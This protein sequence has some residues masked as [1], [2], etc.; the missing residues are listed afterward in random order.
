ML[1]FFFGN[2]TK[3][4]RSEIDANSPTASLSGGSTCDK[5]GHHHVNQ[6]S[7]RIFSGLESNSFDLQQRAATLSSGRRCR[8]LHTSV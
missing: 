7:T 8:A 3:Y 1:E 5:E 6:L 4:F 2:A